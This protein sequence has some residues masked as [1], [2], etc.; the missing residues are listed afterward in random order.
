[1]GKHVLPNGVTLHCDWNDPWL[2]S[3]D[4]KM[5]LW[6]GGPQFPDAA[7]IVARTGCC[8]DC[9]WKAIESAFDHHQKLFWYKADQL[10]GEALGPTAHAFAM[11]HS[12]G[13][14]S[15][16]GVGQ[17]QEVE[18]W[19]EGMVAN[20]QYLEKNV[21]NAIAEYCD[22]EFVLD[23]IEEFGLVASCHLLIEQQTMGMGGEL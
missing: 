21:E 11:G 10:A 12:G 7:E 2:P 15:V 3:I 23:T 9:A 20:W 5:G 19:D 1:M 13:W 22:I 4:V 16:T 8:E 14:L 18:L 6:R 17:G